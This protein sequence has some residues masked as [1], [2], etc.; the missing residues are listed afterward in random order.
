M[1]NEHE[2]RSWWNQRSR[3]VCWPLLTDH[4]ETPVMQADD[5]HPDALGALPSRRLRAR[6]L[7]RAR[8]GA[9]LPDPDDP[10]GCRLHRLAAGRDA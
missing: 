5:C 8:R 4:S 6:R 1:K 3:A 9:R 7:G 2:K 10:D